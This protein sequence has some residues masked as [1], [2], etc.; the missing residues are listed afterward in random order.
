MACSPQW[1]LARV[2]R[3]LK[4]L[5]T[6]GAGQLWVGQTV[7]LGTYTHCPLCGDMLVPQNS[8]TSELEESPRNTHQRHGTAG[9]VTLCRMHEHSCPSSGVLQ[10]RASGGERSR[11]WQISNTFEG[12]WL[13]ISV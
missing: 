2:L 9:T 4:D 3:F 6:E 8:R 12:T 5:W 11:L 10:L 1:L 7:R 13:G